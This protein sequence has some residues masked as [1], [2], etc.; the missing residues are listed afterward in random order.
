[1]DNSLL[2][3][4]QFFERYNDGIFQY[5]PSNCAAEEF[6]RLYKYLGYPSK[7]AKR[8]DMAGF[9][10]L[11]GEYDEAL[12]KQF[13]EVYG[14]NLDDYSAWYTLLSRIGINPIPSTVS[15]C[16]KIIK[17][18]HVNLLDLT[19]ATDPNSTVETFSTQSELRTYSIRTRKFFPREEIHS[20]DILKYL[21]RKFF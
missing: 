8:N 2:P 18:T 9:K 14:T 6:R 7:A 20:G 19:Q 3:L 12:T 5:C 16:K 1:M 11:R 4:A 13:N 17:Q 15:E 10:Q 21:L